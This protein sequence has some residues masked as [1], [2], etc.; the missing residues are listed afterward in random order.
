MTLTLR[1]FKRSLHRKPKRRMVAFDIEAHGFSPRYDE[2]VEHRWSVFDALMGG[3]GAIEAA[4]RF[5]DAVLGDL[6]GRG[7]R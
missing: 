7:R 6:D 3:P 4:D 2:V 5:I 1:Q